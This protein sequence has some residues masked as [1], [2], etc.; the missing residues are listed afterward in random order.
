MLA[1]HSN[2][3]AALGSDGRIYAIGG[4]SNAQNTVEAYGTPRSAISATQGVV[5]QLQSEQAGLFAFAGLTC[6]ILASKSRNHATS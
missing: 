4:T 3:A 6:V 2:L 1:S 5:V